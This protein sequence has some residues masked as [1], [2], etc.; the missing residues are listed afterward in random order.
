MTTIPIKDS[1]AELAKNYDAWLCDIW[2]V[3]HNGEKAHEAAT[4]ACQEFMKQGG[5]V[6]LIT[7]A[8]RPFHAVEKQFER[9]KITKDSYNGIVTSGDVTRA[10]IKANAHL[11][12]FHLGPERD[13]SVMDGISVNLTD[14][15]QADILLCT[16]L[17]DDD[18]ETPEDYTE[19]LQKFAA[20]NVKMICANPDI[21]VER[22]HKLLYCAGALAQEYN[23]IDG[24]VLYAGKPY[25]PIYQEAR[26]KL[27]EIAGNEIEKSRVLCIGDGLH[28]DMAG[29]EQGDFDA[30]FIA[31]GLHMGAGGTG[32][33]DKALA[34]LFDGRKF[35]PVAAQDQLKW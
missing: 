21:Q 33:N 34:E 29:A 28:T 26:K 4:H 25:A 9:F 11:P 6:V 2:G 18:H 23:R 12:M 14:Q 20:R 32:L 3:M 16:G 35:R 7:N 10:L 8:P 15:E 30:L 22:G 27:N 5:H 1:I 17:F 24:H 19:M 31:S 13:T